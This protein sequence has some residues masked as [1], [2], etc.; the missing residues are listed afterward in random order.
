MARPR[1][2]RDERGATAVLFAFLAVILIGVGAL[3]VDVGQAYAKRSLLQT[4]VDLAVMAAAAELNSAGSCNAEVVTVAE[5]YLL[6]ATNAV[7]GQYAVN[8]G[9]A[10]GDS[11]GYISC[12]D[13]K[14]T[15]WAPKSRVDLGLGR[16][17]TDQDSLDVQAH[18]AAQIRSAMGGAT[19]PFFAVEGCDSGPQSIRNPSGPVTVTT[20]PPLTPGSATTNDATFTISPTTV[21]A[22]TTSVTLTLSGKKLT[23][24]TTTQVG[25]TGAGGPPY[26]YVVTP[27]SASKS[28]I[29]VQVP[30]AVLA[31]EDVWY[32]RVLQGAQW[33]EEQLAQ[34]F[35]VGDEKL[36]CDAR[37]EGNFGTIEIPRSDTNNSNW[38]AWNMIRGLQPALAIHPAPNGECSGDPGS[39]ESVRG[40]VDGT[41][42]VSSE[43]GLKVSAT[44]D[45]LVSGAG[46]L[47]GRL[48]ADSTSNCSR[49]HNSDR[50]ASTIKGKHLNDDVLTCF[51]VNGAHLSDLVAG[52]SVGSGALSAA[53]FESPRFFWLP[54]LATDP[55]TGKKSWPII[56]FRPGFI[57]DQ[58]LSA[59]HDAPGTL[60]PFN[61]LVADSSGI[62]E[63][64]VV[65]FSEDALPDFAPAHGGETAYTGSGPKV[66]VLVE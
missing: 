27:T 1:R 13:W 11:D 49:N 34:P 55:S 53:V 38:L 39:V 32:V 17:L 4:D 3:A 40:P 22:G 46:G 33:S 14:V 9:G 8:L 44:N 37:N 25:F 21:P 66:V 36:Y 16:V 64:K 50:T 30:S 58:A 19:L 26:H 28:Q 59:S 7:P 60:T 52:N 54:V 5:E 6:K 45:G 2:S 23:G 62:S 24:P 48:D 29:T 47:K 51:I 56:G 43:T 10:P 65:L 42:C 15:L 61:G 12:A 41:N 18:A 31:V 63:V 35:T 57:T 20:V